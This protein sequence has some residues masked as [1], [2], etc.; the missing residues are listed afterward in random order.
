MNLIDILAPVLMLPLELIEDPENSVEVE[1]LYEWILGRGMDMTQ[2]EA[3]VIM[4][5]VRTIDPSE[6][7]TAA[8]IRDTIRDNTELTV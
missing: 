8:F 3:T 5:A 2:N 6:S 1:A 4:A 7:D